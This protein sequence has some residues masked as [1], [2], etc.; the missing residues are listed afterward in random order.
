L[1]NA[2]TSFATIYSF[3]GGP[4]GQTPNG[5][6]A[7]NDGGLYGTTELGGSRYCTNEDT[8]SYPCG[9]VFEL[10]ND[11]TAWSNTVLYAF[12]GASGGAFPD[13]QLAMSSDGTLYGTTRSEGRIEYGDG[14]VFTVTPPAIPGG[15]WMET[16]IYVFGRNPRPYYGWSPFFPISGVVLGANGQV[17]GVTHY[18]YWT[19]FTTAGGAI[20]EL[21]PSSAPGGSFTE[22]TLYSFSYSATTPGVEPVGGLT[23]DGSSF[24]GTDS[25]GGTANCGA[26]FRA[27]PSPGQATTVVALHEFTGAPDGCGPMAAVTLAPSGAIYGTTANGGFTTAPCPPNGCGVVFRLSPSGIPGAPWTEDVIYRFTGVNGDGAFPSGVLVL[28][29]DGSLYG[30]T[31]GGGATDASNPDCMVSGL[32]GCGAV[33]RLTPSE[34]GAWTQTILHHFTGQNGEGSYPGPYLTSGPGGALYGTTAQGG[35]SGFGT[36]FQISAN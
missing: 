13:G 29:P 23:P 6:I 9:T 12:Q 18:D 3:Q 35:I 2:Q 32:S 8:W 17:F 19:Q 7:G 36:V 34:G 14:T 11:G 25:Q 31:Q 22:Y 27:L 33:F 28:G 24:Y 5:V 15:D 26:A 30:T 20:Y 10:T 4:D 21:Q 16:D 1:S